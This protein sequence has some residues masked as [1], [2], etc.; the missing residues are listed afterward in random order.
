M[1]T[2]EIISLV[3]SS[4]VL[5]AILTTFVNLKIQDLNYKREYYKKIIERRIH[6][7]EE[8]LNLS[9]ELRIQVKLDNSLCNRICATGE[10]HYEKF[11]IQVATSVNISFWLSEEL[12]DIILDLNIFLLNEITHEIQGQNKTE[13]EKCLVSLGIRHHD[14]LRDFRSKI[15]FQLKKDFADMSNVR[16][17]ISPKQKSKDKL[18]W[19]KK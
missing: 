10:D 2:T 4:S 12:S 14:K 6:A 1:E 11:V 13:R 8:I 3:V 7:Q 18:Y 19:I 16:R 5:S 15:D 9:N 17:F